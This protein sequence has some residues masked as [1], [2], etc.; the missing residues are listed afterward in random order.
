V[1]QKWPDIRQKDNES[2][3]QY[4]SQCTECLLELKTKTD[5]LD[6]NVQLQL[7]A[8][9]TAVYKGIEETVRIRITREFRIRTQALTF[10]LISGFHSIP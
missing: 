10:N 7:T 1:I 2:V 8:A 4:V 5:V 3:I 9:D 6:S